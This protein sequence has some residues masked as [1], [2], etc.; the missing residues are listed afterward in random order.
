EIATRLILDWCG[1]EASEL[2][3][4]GAETNWRREISFRPERPRTL[5][6]V[7]VEAG[8]S[9]RIL[10]A[11]G[12]EVT[13]GKD[14]DIVV[15]P[16]WRGDIVG[17]A[18]LVEEVVRVH[19]YDHVPAVPMELTTALPHPALTVNQ[20][21]RVSARRSL[22]GRG[23]IEAVTL[24]FMASGQ[25]SLFGETPESV[26]LVNPISSDLDV[27]RPSILPNLISAAGRND[28]RG[29]SNSRLFEVG[30]QFAGDA[31]EDETEVAAG[32]RSG[33]TGPRDW[34]QPPRPV[35]VYDAKADAIA[36]LAAAG[37][38]V[39]KLQ[40]AAEAPSW[41]H[42]GRSGSL[43]LGPK[44]VLAWFGEI[45]PRVLKALDV[46]GPMVGF[47]VFLDRIP[48][49]KRKKSAAKA[50]LKL[51]AFQPVERDFAFV[52]DQDVPADEVLRAARSADTKLVSEVRVF[53]LFA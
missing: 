53:D 6:G 9:R 18:C 32:I 8:E 52:L 25:A 37:T 41:Y 5:G 28:D 19:G 29:F 43:R 42:P 40:V 39:E 35:D 31:P 21:R 22:A 12:F 48:A 47:E 11:L 20:S 30:P 16:S 46:K 26:T 1:G 24:S 7:D 34:G 44:V 33:Q 2:V 45:H 10:T 13:P 27:M 50:H 4:A 17:E 14:A 23:M 36:A 15:P 51:S 49:P 3:V 38:P